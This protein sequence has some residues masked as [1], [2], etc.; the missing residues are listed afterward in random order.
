[1]ETTKFKTETVKTVA[2][3]TVLIESAL[4][5]IREANSDDILLF[6]GQPVDEPLLPK[7]A[8]LHNIRRKWDIPQRR[9]LHEN[10]LRML[11][12]FKLR[13]RPF[14]SNYP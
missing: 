6:R 14:L 4:R 1:M 3:Y 10:E 12:E 13:S 7:V 2:E 11:D 8:R 5:S 9:S